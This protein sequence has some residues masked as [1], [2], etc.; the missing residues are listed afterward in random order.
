MPETS[1]WKMLTFNWLE[2]TSSTAYKIEAL[3]ITRNPMV[4][5]TLNFSEV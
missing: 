1:T 5:E 2:L 3:F 4:Y